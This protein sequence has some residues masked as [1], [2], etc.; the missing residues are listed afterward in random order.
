MDTAENKAFGIDDI[1]QEILSGEYTKDKLPNSAISFSGEHEAQ[2]FSNLRRY[3]Q[4][5][6]AELV[7]TSG[8][9]LDDL[10]YLKK[11][12]EL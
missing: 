6:L 7:I 8:Q 11:I 2:Y 3:L 10:N 12:G 9:C 1:I 4:S 5:D